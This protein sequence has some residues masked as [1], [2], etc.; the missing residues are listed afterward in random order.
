MPA[1]TDALAFVPLFD[2]RAECIDPSS[3]LVARCAGLLD[4]G[5]LALLDEHI[6]VTDS[7]RIDL[8]AHLL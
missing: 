5:P 6:A 8:Y 2:I 4:T 3:D 7:A 1:D